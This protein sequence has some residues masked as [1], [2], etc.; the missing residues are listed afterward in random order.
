[1]VASISIVRPVMQFKSMP[2]FASRLLIAFKAAATPIAVTFASF[3]TFCA[4]SAC[5][6]AA[7]AFSLLLVL[8]VFAEV[9]RWCA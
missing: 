2:S 8:F 3:A 6:S 1:M 5:R 4:D 7:A 9:W